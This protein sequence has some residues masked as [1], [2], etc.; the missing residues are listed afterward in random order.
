MFLLS[1]DDLNIH[2]LIQWKL[3]ESYLSTLNDWCERNRLLLNS[4]ECSNVSFFGKKIFQD[5][6][7]NIGGYKLVEVS[8]I[9]DLRVYQ[10]KN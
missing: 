2:A 3:S 6:C 5:V 7:Y 10:D 9:K 1:A 8:S 4:E